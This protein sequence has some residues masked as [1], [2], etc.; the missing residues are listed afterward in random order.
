LRGAGLADVRC[1]EID[2]WDK[3]REGGMW[4]D[5]SGRVTIV[6]VVETLNNS[7]SSTAEGCFEML[8]HFLPRQLRATR[9]PSIYI[10]GVPLI[11]VF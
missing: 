1:M 8:S 5:N 9:L 6:A 4:K 3:L 10:I 11:E 7:S 2:R